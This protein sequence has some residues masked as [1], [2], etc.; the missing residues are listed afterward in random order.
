MATVALVASAQD[1]LTQDESF[2]A[3]SGWNTSSTRHY[4]VTT[5]SFFSNWFVSAGI[6]GTALYNENEPDGTSKS[7]FKSFRNNVGLS[8]AMGKWFTPGLGLRMKLNGF[9]GKGL[10]EPAIGTYES[11]KYLSFQLQTMFNASNLFVGYNPDRFY[12]CIP[13]LGFGLM[14]NLSYNNNFTGV[15][16]GLLNTFRLSDRVTFN[17]DLSYMHRNKHKEAVVAPV[18]QYLSSAGVE[19]GF[20]YYIGNSKWKKAPDVEAI[21]EM[22]Q[23]EID[24]IKAQLEDEQMENEMLRQQIEQPQS[25]E[26]K[27]PQSDGKE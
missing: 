1:E 5:N 4:S 7:P 10:A 9:W 16:V 24:A 23:M 13:Y 2:E 19:I 22:Y 25:D 21:H 8:M 6:V 15:S 14:R 20:T 3:Q 12:N 17:I 11:I 18:C 26:E 27:Q